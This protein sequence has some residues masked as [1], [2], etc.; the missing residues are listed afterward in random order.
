MELW[1]LPGVHSTSNRW[2]RRDRPFE[3]ESQS[4]V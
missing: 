4:A 2:L 3:E 1:N